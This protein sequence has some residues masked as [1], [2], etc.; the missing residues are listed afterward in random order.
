MSQLISGNEPYFSISRGNMLGLIDAIVHGE[1]LPSQ[2]SRQPGGPRAASHAT[3]LDIAI[4]SCAKNPSL[5]PTSSAAHTQ[6]SPWLP[7]GNIPMAL[8]HI[9]NME[10]SRP[11]FPMLSLTSKSA[12]APGSI[13]G[14]PDT[15]GFTDAVKIP[16]DQPISESSYS[17]LHKSTLERTGQL[18]AMKVIH[19]RGLDTSEMDDMN[20]FIPRLKREIMALM[21]LDS[22]RIVPYLGFVVADDLPCLITPWF[23]NGNVNDYLLK[24]PGC[25]R[26]QLV[27]GMRIAPGCC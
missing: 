2:L 27:S 12:G 14:S 26:R 3:L 19:G 21:P 25:D 13:S 6:L 1:S 4:D 23:S 11:P 5:R 15:A 18:V 20:K 9:E 7:A 16:R 24:T 22:P 8:A 10:N 17:T